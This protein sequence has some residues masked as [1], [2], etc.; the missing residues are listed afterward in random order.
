MDGSVGAFEK[1]SEEGD[2][3]IVVRMGCG[4]CIGDCRGMNEDPGDDAV[5]CGDSPGEL[6]P[7]PWYGSLRDSSDIMLRWV[8]PEYPW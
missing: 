5:W 1:F 4:A 3:K 2:G 7:P 6:I 8:Y